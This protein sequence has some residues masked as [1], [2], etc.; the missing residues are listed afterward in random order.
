LLLAANPNLTAEQLEYL[1]THNVALPSSDEV[2]T[3][4][5]SVASMTEQEVSPSAGT[6][7]EPL[8][9][10]N[11]TFQQLLDLGL[12][13]SQLKEIFGPDLPLSNMKVKDYCTQQS[14]AFSA[15]KAQ[16]TEL[17]AETP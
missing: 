11:T 9:N 4:P 10:G 14:I 7:G 13:T 6:E 3:L 5:E 17:L 16:L 8:V 2:S 1:S 12:T 15:V